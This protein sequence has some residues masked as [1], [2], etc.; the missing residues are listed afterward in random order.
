MKTEKQRR[1]DQARQRLQ[2]KPIDGFGFPGCSSFE[3]WQQYFQS[4]NCLDFVTYKSK[5]EKWLGMKLVFSE[6]YITRSAIKSYN[7]S[8]DLKK[9]T[10]GGNILRS[11]HDRQRPRQIIYPDS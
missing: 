5:M 11:V 7:L 4:L 10:S 2:Q 1:V 8:Y 9:M 3:T 6:W